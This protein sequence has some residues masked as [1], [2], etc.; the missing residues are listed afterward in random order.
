[1]TLDFLFY[2]VN[3]ITIQV[4]FSL[5]FMIILLTKK[6]NYPNQFFRD[7]CIAIPICM[8]VCVEYSNKVNICSRFEACTSICMWVG[9]CM[10]WSKEEPKQIFT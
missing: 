6:F 7:F 10:G 4:L 3:N 8:N 2:Y 5:Y 9:E 1:M